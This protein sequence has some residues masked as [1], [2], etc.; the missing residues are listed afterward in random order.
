[1]FPQGVLVP[2]L[3]II[4]NTCGRIFCPGQFLHSANVKERGGGVEGVSES[5]IQML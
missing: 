1:M 5:L 4:I 3:V 2:N